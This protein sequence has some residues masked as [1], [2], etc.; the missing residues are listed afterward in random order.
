MN[1]EGMVLS[2]IAYG[3]LGFISA[4]VAFQIPTLIVAHVILVTGDSELIR[5][6]ILIQFFV[7][8]SDGNTYGFGN[9]GNIYKRTSSSVYS[10]VYTDGT[11]RSIKGAY[12]WEHDDGNNYLYWA[13]DTALC[14]KPLPGA[15]DWSDVEEDIQTLSAADWHAMKQAGGSLLMGNANKLAMVDYAGNFTDDA[16]DIRPGNVVKCLEEKDDFVIIGSTREDEAEFGYIW[17]WY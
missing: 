14:R 10:V 8:A 3:I 2:Q 1:D 4:V 11:A 5:V 13:Y 16:M 6:S 9:A 17:S 12:E 15:S 7:G